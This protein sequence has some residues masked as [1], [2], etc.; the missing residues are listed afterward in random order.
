MIKELAGETFE[1]G[2]AAFWL[3]LGFMA[4]MF[5]IYVG[6]YVN[7]CGTHDVVQWLSMKSDL[8]ACEMRSFL[9]IE[10]EKHEAEL[11]HIRAV[12]R[13]DAQREINRPA[14]EAQQADRDAL[15]AK[16]AAE[17][18]TARAEPLN[19]PGFS[20]QPDTQAAREVPV[21]RETVEE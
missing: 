10:Q 15:V 16:R 13:S 2:M 18:E 9:R 17:I 21:Q 14:M 8:R 12:K 3:F 7:L 6:G 4:L 19:V 20:T 11:E 1:I 5:C